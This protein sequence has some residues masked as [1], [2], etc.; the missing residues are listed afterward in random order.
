MSNRG[1][2]SFDTDCQNWKADEAI[3][4]LFNY[5]DLLTLNN[6]AIQL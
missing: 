4:P 2:V 6:P 3:Q 5:L 1:S